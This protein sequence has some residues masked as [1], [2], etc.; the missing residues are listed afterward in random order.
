MSFLLSL[1]S[2]LNDFLWNGPMLILLCATHLYFTIRLRFVQRH[3]GKA[4]RYSIQDAKAHS[5]MAPKED[6]QGNGFSA[7]TTTLAAT[8]GT[9]NIVGIS[10]A[11][12]FGGPGAVFWCWLTGLFGMATTYAECYLGIRYRKLKNG[13]Y[14]GGPMYALEYGLGKKGLG[15]LFAFATLFASCGMGGSTQTRTVTEALEGRFGIPPWLSGMILALTVGLVLIAGVRTIGSICM[16]LVPAMAFFYMAGCI[17]LLIL[18]RSVLPQTLQ[19]ILESAFVPRAIAGGLIGGSLKMA[20]RYGISRGLFTN[21]AGLGSA[22]IAAADVPGEDIK[23]QSLISMSATFWDTVIMCAVT[24]MV[25]VSSLIKNPNAANG[26]QFGELT[27]AAFEGIPV[28]G[29]AMLTISL[30]AFA[31]ATLIGWSYFGEKAADYLFGES[32]IKAYRLCYILMI[33]LGS[34]L[35]TELVWELSDFS[36]A[37]MAFPNLI[38]LFLLRKEIK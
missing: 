16:H 26:Y 32:G 1:F 22:A 23:R 21:E 9:G 7:L 10:T 33:F 8:L 11:I 2:S 34:V 5:A 38:A 6:G 19:I 30:V 28:I 27:T 31:V 13:A 29:T 24:G 12:A 20:M 36:N 17:I 15:I 14:A 4:I 3:I 37:L 25:I 35:A 18:N